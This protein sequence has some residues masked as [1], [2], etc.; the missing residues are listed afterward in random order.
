MGSARASERERQAVVRDSKGEGR[1]PSLDGLC[2]LG[3][4]QE[5]RLDPDA[6][7]L[8]ATPMAV[9]DSGAR[10]ATRFPFHGS[11]Y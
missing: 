9:G 1:H 3:G 5:F 4:I 6:V 8:A 11:N 10:R 7:A 2:G